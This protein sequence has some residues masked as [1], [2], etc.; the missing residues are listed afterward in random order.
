MRIVQATAT[1]P[2]VPSP[3]AS[4]HSVRARMSL[5]FSVAF[6]TFLRAK[7]IPLNGGLTY[8]FDQALASGLFATLVNVGHIPGSG[9]WHKNMQRD[10]VLQIVSLTILGNCHGQH[11]T[12]E[13]HFYIGTTVNLVYGVAPAVVNWREWDHSQAARELVNAFR[14]TG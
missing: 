13:A 10:H 14:H 7:K 4:A 9:T 1:W 2:A 6:I 11:T 8:M 12:G 5:S 3:R